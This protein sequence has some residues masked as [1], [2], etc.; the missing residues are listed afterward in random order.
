MAKQDWLI[1]NEGNCL[2]FKSPREW[3]LLS[4]TNPYRLY[5]FLVELEDLINQTEIRGESEE[6]LLHNIRPLVRK[7]ILNVYWLKTNIPDISNDIGTSFSLLYDEPGFSLTIQTEIMLPQTSTSIHNHGT[8]GIVA[9]LGGQQKNTFWRR[10]PTS[11]FPDKIEQV[12]E[13]IFSSGDIISLMT[14]TIHRVEAI[15]DEPTITLNLYGE[16]LSKRFNFDPITH[17]AK[18]F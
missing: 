15:G 6:A 13:Q 10:S 4:E 12:G 5:R 16:T 7:L 3:D 18:K 1:T 11:D 14:D 2:A 17:Q 8:W 9:T